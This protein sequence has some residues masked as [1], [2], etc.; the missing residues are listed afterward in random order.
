[1]LFS[2]C[3]LPDHRFRFLQGKFRVCLQLLGQGKVLYADYQSVTQHFLLQLAVLT[4]FDQLVE[5]RNVLLS[6]F[7]LSLR[8]AVEPGPFKNS[9]P[10]DFK[11]RV[12][13]SHY[14]VVLFPVLC[15]DVS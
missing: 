15:A 12:E 2:G 9:I 7:A 14:G 3:F 5:F 6:G 8:P 4:K 13:L 1:M 10:S 11:V